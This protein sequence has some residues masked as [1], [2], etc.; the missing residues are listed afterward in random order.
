MTET[1]IITTKRGMRGLDRGSV[2]EKMGVRGYD[3]FVGLCYLG[4]LHSLRLRAFSFSLLLY[5][6]EEGKKVLPLL[7]VLSAWARRFH[8]LNDLEGYSDVW[9]FGSTTGRFASFCL[10]L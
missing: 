4:V 2:N 7:F 6:S 3:M 9:V 8:S 10:P 5:D 1:I